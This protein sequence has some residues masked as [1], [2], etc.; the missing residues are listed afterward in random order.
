MRL[1]SVTLSAIPEN[2]PAVREFIAAACADGSI[3]EDVVFALTMA[4][5]EVCSNLIEHGYEGVERGT[6]RLDLDREGDELAL[7]IADDGKPFS[8]D[9]APEPDLT[10]DWQD[11]QVGGL[12]LYLVRQF[13]DEV[14]YRT[15]PGGGNVLT[16]VKRTV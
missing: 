9:S 14:T 13:V 4:A 6:M 15:D 8:P 16:L 2:I 11:R 7:R 12:G 3:A 5:D 10:S 1:G